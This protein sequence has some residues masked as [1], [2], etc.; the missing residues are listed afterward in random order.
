M[1]SKYHTNSFNPYMMASAYCKIYCILFDFH[2]NIINNASNK[3]QNG[4]IMLLKYN[5]NTCYIFYLI[6]SQ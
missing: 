1:S 2:N 5:I 3:L 6:S 4:N